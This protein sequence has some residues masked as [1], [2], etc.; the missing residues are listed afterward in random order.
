MKIFNYH[1]IMKRDTDKGYRRIFFTLKKLSI[2][3]KIDIISLHRWE[4]L[5]KQ[6]IN[7]K[8]LS[9]IPL[10][11]LFLVIISGCGGGS[12]GSNTVSAGNSAM[13]GSVTLD[14]DAPTTNSDG[15]SLTDLAGYKIYY[16]TSSRNYTGSVNVGNYTGTEISSL[17]SGTWCFAV[18]AYDN[19]GNESDYS[20]EV[21]KAI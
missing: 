1:N 21:C 7:C 16:G 18:T 8:S 3:H 19:A 17:A 11:L 5:K 15:S 20:D 12:G 2:M 4:T 9:T 6:A 14:W 10:I 13:T